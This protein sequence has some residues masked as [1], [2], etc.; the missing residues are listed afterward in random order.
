[1]FSVDPAN[2]NAV[3]KD[4]VPCRSPPP[5]SMI[6]PPFSDEATESV[7]EPKRLMPLN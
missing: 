6:P 5:T 7:D 4:D 3:G 2:E 1:L